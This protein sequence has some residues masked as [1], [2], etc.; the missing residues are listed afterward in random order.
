MTYL[1]FD[2]DGTILNTETAILK[3]LQHVLAEE[4]LHY[5]LHELTFA[6]GVPGKDT[7]RTIGITDIDRVHPKWSQLV[8]QYSNEVD[9]FDTLR[10]ILN[11]LHKRR[12]PMSIVTSKMRQ[13]IKDEFEPFN[14]QHY[15]EEI[16]SA[17][18]TT[19]HK[20]NPEPLL[21]C[22][23]HLN[24]A[25]EDAIYIG[26]SIYDL[27]CA[28]AAGVRFALAYWGAKKT[29]GFEDADFILRTPS[30]I[31]TLLEHA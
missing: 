14:I 28:H 18:D 24:I 21:L 7:L 10:D 26:D 6:L 2:L 23:Q 17:D 20:P 13:E 1:I 31:Y 5:E 29:V 27:Q 4:Q 8:L 11:D 3:S 22:L 30:E 12:V 9:I 16:I 15:F 25:K 19:K